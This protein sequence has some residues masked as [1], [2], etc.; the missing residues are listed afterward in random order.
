MKTNAIMFTIVALAMVLLAGCTQN[1]VLVSLEASVAATE[2]LVASLEV[3]G[4]ISPAI[5]GEIEN[6]IAGLPAA[7]QETAAELSSTDNAAAKATKI[8]AYYTAT[9]VALQALPP[10]AQ[11]Y[12]SAI[13]ASIQAFLSV[14][15]PAQA[16]RSSARDAK[17]E[18]FDGKRL[19]AIAARAA[20]LGAQ[21]AELQDN[22]AKA[23]KAGTR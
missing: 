5:A 12:A 17:S 6:A 3:A 11:I 19:S 20:V 18:R 15:Q 14:L 9:I 21:L 8:G 23:G 4:E 2:T 1:Q 10:E 13:S 22:T 7:F 16:T